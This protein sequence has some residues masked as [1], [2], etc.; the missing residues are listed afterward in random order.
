MIFGQPAEYYLQVIGALIIFAIVAP[1]IKNRIE[2]SNRD[3]E[4]RGDENERRDDAKK[5]KRQVQAEAAKRMQDFLEE[6]CAEVLGNVMVNV[7]RTKNQHEINM[8]L[9]S[10]PFTTVAFVVVNIFAFDQNCQLCVIYDGSKVG[11]YRLSDDN[12]TVALRQLE[13]LLHAD[14]KII[15]REKFRHY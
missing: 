14:G 10:P 12:I 11:C 2:A 4:R 13:Q 1:F 7:E 9:L 3:T 5:E 6:L 8:D 15:K